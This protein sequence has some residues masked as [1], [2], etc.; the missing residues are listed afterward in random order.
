MKSISVSQFQDNPSG[1]LHDCNNEPIE[2]TKYG[3]PVAYVVSPQM[4]NVTRSFALSAQSLPS[5]SGI[6]GISQGDA[7]MAENL[8]DQYAKTNQKE[9]EVKQVEE[10]H[11]HDMD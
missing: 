4:V 6:V 10:E 1:Y 5:G 3:K 7:T 11:K 8:M 9:Q 2:L